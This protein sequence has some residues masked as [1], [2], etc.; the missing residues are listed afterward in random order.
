VLARLRPLF[1]DYLRRQQLEEENEVMG[2]A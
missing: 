1:R 2:S